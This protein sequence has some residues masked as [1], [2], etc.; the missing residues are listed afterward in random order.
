MPRSTTP[1]GSGR[2]RSTSRSSTPT[3]S[4][5]RSRRSC[6]RTRARSQKLYVKSPV[7]GQQIPLSTFAKFDTQHVT[8]LSINHQSQ[9][10][11]VTLSFNLAPGVAL[12]EA[13][14]ADQPG[15]RRT[16]ACRPR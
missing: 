8:Y 9:F 14:D 10:P 2:W 12:G 4:S 6:S 1:S 11:A 7:T 15:R 5:W 13:V 3:T 16:W